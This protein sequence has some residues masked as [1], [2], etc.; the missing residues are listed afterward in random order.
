M[1]Q[2]A[3][4]RRPAVRIVRGRRLGI[5]GRDPLT[6]LPKAGDDV[7]D[8]KSFLRILNRGGQ[9]LRELERPEPRVELVP[10]VDAP[11]DRPRE[12]TFT[13]DEFHPFLLEDFAV[14]GVGTAAAG[15]EAV[16]FLRLVVPIN[17]EQVAPHP[18]AHRL[19]EA[20]HGIGGNGRV[21][22]R[23]ARLENV[24]PDLGRQRHAR[25]DNAVTGD[26]RRATLVPH[27]RRPVVL[28]H[29]LQFA[30]R[31]LLTLCRAV[32][33]QHAPKNKC[34]DKEVWTAQGQQ[35]HDSLPPAVASSVHAR[36]AALVKYPVSTSVPRLAKRG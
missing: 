19:G 5:V 16:K 25:R 24:E 35:S 23:S 15:V 18:A 8:G 13:R 21:G 1:K 4:P 20:Q 28:A 17:A 22:R 34:R 10:T 6:L 27:L 9:Q 12:H 29:L 32:L 36:R 2:L 30:L 33:H 11:G 26:G 31:R 7:G 3:H 14:V